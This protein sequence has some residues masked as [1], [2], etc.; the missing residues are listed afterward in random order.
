MVALAAAKYNMAIMYKYLYAFFFSTCAGR[1]LF[2]PFEQLP[3]LLLLLPC[4]PYS[5]CEM[6]VAFYGA[7]RA[8]GKQVSVY[9]MHAQ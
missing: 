3:R 4:C 5:A 8:P 2:S 7:C 1:N 6:N 9:A